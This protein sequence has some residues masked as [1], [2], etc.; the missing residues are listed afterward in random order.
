MYKLI[1]QYQ[2]AA[3]A[4]ICS[5]N[6]GEDPMKRIISS[7]ILAIATLLPITPAANAQDANILEEITVTAQRREQNLQEVPI[8]ITAFTGTQIDRLNIQGATDYLA[9][10]PN[11]SFTH[12]GQSGTRGLGLAI[13][14]IN[15]L[16]R[17]AEF[18]L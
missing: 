11:V 12:D 16:D 4:A 15:N 10:T 5:S 2:A 18:V 1:Q 9:L 3:N 14:G 17:F 13:R 8:A 6:E 7:C